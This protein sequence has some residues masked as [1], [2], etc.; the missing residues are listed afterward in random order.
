MKVRV[1]TIFWVVGMLMGAATAA[2]KLKDGF[3]RAPAT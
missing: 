2:E 1:I 3:S